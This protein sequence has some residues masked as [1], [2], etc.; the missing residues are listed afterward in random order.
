MVRIA[1]APSLVLAGSLL[2]WSPAGYGKPVRPP[3][4]LVE[5][6]TP[7]SVLAVLRAGYKP[8]IHPSANR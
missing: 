2:P 1:G 5:T 4:A 6:L 8:V 7:P 3:A